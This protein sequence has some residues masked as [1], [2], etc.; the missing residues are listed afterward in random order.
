MEKK[1]FLHMII[2][3]ICMVILGRMPAVRMRAAEED[4]ALDL[5]DKFSYKE[6]F[7]EKE[8]LAYRET[9]IAQMQDGEACLVVYLH[10]KS[11]SGQDNQSQLAKQGVVNI[12]E[13]LEENEK[14]SFVLVPQCS[15]EK[16]WNETESDEALVTEVLYHLILD[17]AGMR[18]ISEDCI[19]I[20]GDSYGARGVWKM[21]S[22]YSDLFSGAMAVAAVP[23]GKAK[24]ISQTPVC[25]VL[26]G[27]DHW[28]SIAES[29]EKVEKWRKKNVTIRFEVMEDMTHTEVCDQAFTEERIAWVLKQ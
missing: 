20:F 9:S 8:R 3:M 2:L 25:C 12:V 24:N 6:F 28:I 23:Q 19:Y 21:L 7:F 29:E 27:K 15:M 22:D 13:Y 10:G 17:Y 18:N 11:A 26:G 4:T 5:E 16:V 1:K 14:K